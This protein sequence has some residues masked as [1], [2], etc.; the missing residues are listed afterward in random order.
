MVAPGCDHRLRAV[1][2]N[3]TPRE[4]GPPITARG[5]TRNGRFVL[6]GAFE[7]SNTV[8]FAYLSGPDTS[9]S[10]RTPIPWR[11]PRQFPE[12]SFRG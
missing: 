7:G 1:G 10:W 6:A 2:L 12:L 5:D 11:C 4:C 3:P 9:T 8:D